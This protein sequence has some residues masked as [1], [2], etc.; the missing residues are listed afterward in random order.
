MLAHVPRRRLDVE[1][2]RPVHKPVEDRCC[3]DGVAGAY[4]TPTFRLAQTQQIHERHPPVLQVGEPASD[5]LVETASTR[6]GSQSVRGRCNPPRGS[7][8]FVGSLTAVG[9]AVR[10]R[11][12]FPFRSEAPL[13]VGGFIALQSHSPARTGV[14][15]GTVSRK[16]VIHKHLQ[17]FHVE[18]VRQRKDQVGNA[19]PNVSVNL[20]SHLVRRANYP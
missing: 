4:A 11:N 16:H 1:D 20:L 15:L 17:H 10:P 6:G 8:S 14:S 19:N 18:G 9:Q 5:T 2:D 12:L 13:I 3:N 7:P